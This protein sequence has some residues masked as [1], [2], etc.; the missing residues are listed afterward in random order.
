MSNV[1]VGC[2]MH[3][4]RTRKSVRGSV[5]VENGR[6]AEFAVMRFCCVEWR[7]MFIS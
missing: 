3:T 6:L 7:D 1:I 2:W 4:S 5:K